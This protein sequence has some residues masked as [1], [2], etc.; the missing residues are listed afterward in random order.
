MQ[1]I[2]LSKYDSSD[3]YASLVTSINLAENNTLTIDNLS[4]RVNVANEIILSDYNILSDYKGYLSQFCIWCECPEKYFYKPEYVAKIIYG[5]VD[6]WYLIMWFNDISS[7]LEFNK[8]KIRVFDPAKI[9]IIN[10]IIVSSRTDI[11]N[12]H[13]DPELVEKNIYKKVVIRD[14]SI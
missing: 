4:H 3:S 13:K 1:T 11:L 9:T 8:T 7:P 14:T 6:L 12:N 2:D 10:K 5:S